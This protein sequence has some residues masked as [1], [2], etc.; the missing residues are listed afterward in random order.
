M[1]DPNQKPGSIVRSG[2]LDSST[3]S[4]VLNEDEKL[5]DYG[6]FPPPFL[7]TK[8]PNFHKNVVGFYKHIQVLQTLFTF[9]KA[10]SNKVIF[11]P[12]RSLTK[13]DLGY[14]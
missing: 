2:Y 13:M 3:T 8:L 7:P 1:D 4:S 11:S 5:S 10:N 6:K 12:L 9:L 14:L